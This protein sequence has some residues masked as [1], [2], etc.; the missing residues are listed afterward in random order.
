MTTRREALIWL[1]AA[2]ASPGMLRAASTIER[3]AKPLDILFL[4][5]TGFLG[6]HQVEYALARGH[7]V[8]LFNRGR[9]SPGL[10]GGKVEVLI[11]NRDADVAPGLTA[12]EGKRRWDVVV[13]NSGYVPRHVRDSVALL[14]ERCD[15]YVYVST[16]A[17]YDPAKGPVFDESSPLRP[18][19]NPPTEEVKGETY[20]ALKAE[21]D[22]IVQ[23]ALG[24][25]AT[26]VRPTYVVGPGDDTDRFTYWVDRVARGGEVLGPPDPKVEL[27]WIDVRDLCP[28]IVQLGERGQPG[29]FNAAGPTEPIDWGAVLAS[30]ASL[31][32]QPVTFRWATPQVLQETA[33]RLPLV[34]SGGVLLPPN[35]HFDGRKAAGAGL[36]YRPLRDT[37]TATLDWWRKQTPERR[38]SAEGWPTPE[39]ERQALDRLRAP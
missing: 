13:D 24:A 5:G 39:Q 6:P 21:C 35:A 30:L 3:A 1:A 33:I 11:G 26:I 10:Y 18:A 2:A 29:I 27:Q 4:G 37:A 31:S 17:V 22:R 9:S 12:L 23:A 32:A 7:R 20:G 15:R 16:V 28:W 38:A 25:K 34:R 8:T 14:R 36:A 19:P